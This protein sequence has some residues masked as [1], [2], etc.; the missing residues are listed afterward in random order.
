MHV[1]NVLRQTGPHSPHE[2]NPHVIVIDADRAVRRSFS[3]LLML[4]G[5]DISTRSTVA[6]TLAHPPTAGDAVLVSYAMPKLDG[7]TLLIQ[8]RCDGWR[9]AGILM[10]GFRDRALAR[11]MASA[12]DVVLLERPVAPS[13]L[14]DAILAPARRQLAASGA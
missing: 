3:L 13:A 4:R 1:K 9:G 6:Q 10:S 2:V 7:L 11:R 5:F 14:I 12:P 8:L